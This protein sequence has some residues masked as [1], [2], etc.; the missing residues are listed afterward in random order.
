MTRECKGKK[1]CLS[2]VDVSVSD[3]V[4]CKICGFLAKNSHGLSIHMRKHKRVVDVGEDV[5]SQGCDENVPDQ[6]VVF[7]SGVL[8]EFGFLL[9]KCRLSVPITRI[10]HKSVRT[11]VCQELAKTIEN[12][13]VSNDVDSWMRLIAFPYIVS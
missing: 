12:L 8:D 2:I 6:N 9:N 11:V 3:R 4:S 1:F 5:S 13:L 10:I 7:L